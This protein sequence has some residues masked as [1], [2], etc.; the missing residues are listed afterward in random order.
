MITSPL[1]KLVTRGFSK[2][3]CVSTLVGTV[4]SGTSYAT[5]SEKKELE[6]KFVT[7]ATG[8]VTGVYYPTGGAI[9]RLV[10][11]TR[12]EHSIRCSV[13]STDGS[14]ANLNA[15]RQG[16][17]AMAIA[18]SDWQYNAYKGQDYFA[19]KGPDTALRSLFSLHTEAFTVVAR[20]D[21]GIRTFDDIKGK[22]VNI[23]NKG[24]G[25]RATMEVL[26]RAEGWT[27]S[28]FKQVTEYKASE[29]PDA[30]CSNKIDV[31]IYSAGHPNG[32]VQ[33]ASNSCETVIVPVDGPKIDALLKDKPYYAYTVV[34]GGMYSGTPND[35][36]TFGVKATVV[37]NDAMPEETAYQI[38]KAVMENINGFK[39]LHP[40]FASLDSAKMVK[41]GN[42][43]PLHKGALRYY[44]EKGLLP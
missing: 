32:A 29:Q 42:V 18:Q 31:M 35:V 16:E 37:V 5:A 28:D 44:K 30:L 40:V 36:R 1:L 25:N 4:A 2:T 21:A 7:I 39:L 33:E 9:C 10:N 24:S 12:K 22:R 11:K 43:A 13:E 17:V 15:V 6:N 27:V 3:L 23:G 38:V 26:L 14:V 41:E 19:E 34:P 8:N 20:A